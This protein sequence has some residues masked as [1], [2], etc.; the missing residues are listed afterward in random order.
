MEAGLLFADGGAWVCAALAL[1]IVFVTFRRPLWGVAAFL[2]ATLTA[3]LWTYR[4]EV[5]AIGLGGTILLLAAAAVVRAPHRPRWPSRGADRGMLVAG[6]L[7]LLAAIGGAANGHGRS[8]LAADAYHYVI[9]IPLAYYATRRLIPAAW[10]DRI[11]DAYVVMAAAMALVLLQISYASGENGRL[12]WL[13]GAVL[14]DGGVQIQSDFAFPHLPLAIVTLRLAERVTP[15]RAASALI[16]A[17]ALVLTYKR[18]YWLSY[19]IGITVAL[20]AVATTR[21]RRAAIAT[22]ATAVCIAGGVALT[23][24]VGLNGDAVRQRSAELA[25]PAQAATMQTRVDEWRGV[26][27]YALERPIGYGFG[28]SFRIPHGDPD[29]PRHHFI[30][31]QYLQWTLQGG[32]GLTLAMLVSLALVL[33]DLWRTRRSNTSVAIAATVIAIGVAGLAVPSFCAPVTGCMLGLAVTGSGGTRP[34]TPA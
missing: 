13:V 6:L 2:A 26:I 9:V 23:V 5:Q 16:L 32:V 4:P 31:N 7:A 17:A 29:A 3:P 22:A 10:V 33:R 20:G 24:A 21:W 27:P 1:L 19:V 25:H 12:V 34:P 18:T 11:L 30:H 15:A 14:D 8:W 28:A